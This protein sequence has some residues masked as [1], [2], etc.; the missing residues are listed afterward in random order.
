MFNEE[1]FKSITKEFKN[2]DPIL[3]IGDIGVDKYTKGNV[4]R[5][6]PEAPV[7]VVEV[8]EEWNKL[9]LAANVSDNLQGLDVQTTLCGVIGEDNNGS[10]L[11]NLLEESKLSTWGIVRC[12]NRMT[13][14]KERVVTNTQQICRVDYE[15][16]DPLNAET[17]ESL[18]RRISEFIGKHSAIILED[19]GKGLFTKDFLSQL[20]PMAKEHDKFVAVDPSRLTDP[21]LYK[22]AQLL[23]PNQV[24]SE[25][26]SA[27]LGYKETNPEKVA[28]VLVDKL[29][30]EKLII[31]LGAQ[32][33]AIFDTKADGKMKM[34]PTVAREVF[35]VSGAGDTAISTI[36]AAIACGASLEHAAW[37]GNCASGVVV[38]KKGTALVTQSELHKFF[39]ELNSQSI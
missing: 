11:E 23:K 38:G 14:F 31:T 28:E 21:L 6:S 18:V 25:M 10:I 27:H 39:N 19:Y 2:I 30:L 8:Y 32:G 7:P 36:V 15:T 37:L 34:I 35:D 17:L 33:M 5:I 12:S 13:T 20:L 26:M 29:A 24:E 1:T 4:K 22:G 3:V 16:S 9:G